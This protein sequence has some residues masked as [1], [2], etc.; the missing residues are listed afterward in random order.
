MKKLINIDTFPLSHCD[1]YLEQ[2]RQA[3]DMFESG[4]MKKLYHPIFS[5]FYGEVNESPSVLVEPGHVLIFCK[6]SMQSYLNLN[7]NLF[8]RWTEVIYG[9]FWLMAATPA[10]ARE[11]WMPLWF[12]L[13]IFEK[14]GHST[15]Q[16][17]CQ[18]GGWAA[19]YNEEK[20]SIALKHIKSMT[21]GIIQ[22]E[23]I[24]SLFLSTKINEGNPD[25]INYVEDTYQK[26]EHLQPIQR[27]QAHIHYFCNV[28]KSRSVL[29]N[30]ISILNWPDLYEYREG[31]MQMLGSLYWTLIY[32]NKY[33][34]LLF[35]VRCL[36][37]KV[38]TSG[39]GIAHAFLLPSSGSNLPILSNSDLVTFVDQD[40][41]NSYMKLIKLCN[42]LNKVAT[43]LLG[44]EDVDF[45]I[46]EERFGTPSLDENFEQLRQ[47]VIFHYHLND[48]FYK[49]LQLISLLPS[50][51]HPLQGALCTLG[52]VP[53]LISISL[54][55]LAEEPDE[56]KFLFF[57]SSETYTHDLEVEWVRKEFGEDA[58]IFTNPS[59]EEFIQ[60]LNNER[61]THVYISAHGK[62]NHWLDGEELIYFSD[63]SQIPASVLHST[64]RTCKFM[65]TIVL[66]ICDGATSPLSFNHNNRGLAAGLASGNQ[67]VIGHMIAWTI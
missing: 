56:R 1:F 27:L 17:R 61:Y 8:I 52:I 18:M 57:L 23:A 67:I 29:N 20:S 55:S 44:D 42:C 31:N 28:S 11:I 9:Y 22:D 15:L 36:K 51:N 19:C 5:F 41:G 43:S 47:A 53:P 54:E 46:D 3:I 21:L 38:D 14:A 16:A 37:G 35:F 24:R 25:F 26:S 4:E 39:L 2:M 65:R 7:P 62:Y 59:N 30:I 48:D 45:E 60:L 58:E 63:E 34:D 32:E 13:D 66:N 40:N 6:N 10:L 64:K 33:E 12:T 50:H 49:E